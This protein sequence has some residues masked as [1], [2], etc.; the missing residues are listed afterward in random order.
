MKRI[1]FLPMF[2]FFTFLG[3]AHAST[4]D[5]T[6]V[7]HGKHIDIKDNA[8]G[9]KVKVSAIDETQDTITYK[10]VFE[11]LYSD[12]KSF[13]TWTVVEDLGIQIPLLTSK[14]VKARQR[15][16]MKPHWTGFG[17][18]I[19]TITDG[20]G[21]YNT[22]GNMDIDLSESNEYTYNCI[23]HITPIVSNTIGITTGLGI[24]WRNYYLANEDVYEKVD[25]LTTI[26]SGNPDFHY[27][28]SRLHTVHL[29]M[30]VLIEFQP[31]HYLKRM[32]YL[33]AGVVGNI[34][35]CSYTKTKYTNAE[36]GTVRNKEKGVNVPPISLDYMA[37]AGIGSWSVYA[38]Y[39]PFS[40]FE[41]DKGPHVHHTS[42]GLM[43]DL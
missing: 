12:N 36:G 34:K 27:K 43:I 37:K 16:R 17:Y 23:E 40:I 1:F 41:K 26:A 8:D 33:S 6:I 20:E 4:C 5:T 24:M 18:G 39:S 9:V 42:I 22:I 19:S 13:E 28:Y 3:T 2:T 35:T 32:P 21:H 25:G 31:I 7:Y 10:P 15:K 14:K 29:T 38:K 11:G 30:P